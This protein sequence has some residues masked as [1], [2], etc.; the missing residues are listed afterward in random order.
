MNAMKPMAS[1]AIRRGSPCRPLLI[2]GHQE[3]GRRA[4]TENV[5]YI[6]GVARAMGREPATP[7]QVRQRLGIGRFD[8][9]RTQ[10]A[11]P[12]VETRP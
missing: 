11:D 3:E 8:G 1:S 12:I 4:G 10:A 2:G 5:P 9:A 7:D 6:V